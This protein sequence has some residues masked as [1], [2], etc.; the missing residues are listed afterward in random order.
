MKFHLQKEALLLVK[1]EDGLRLAV[2]A[3]QHDSVSYLV[4]GE[5]LPETQQAFLRARRRT[6]I[7]KTKR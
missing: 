6:Q 5:K 1:P 2:P 3:A 7:N 4:Q